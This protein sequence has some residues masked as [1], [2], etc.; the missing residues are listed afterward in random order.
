MIPI[1]T[2]MKRIVAKPLRTPVVVDDVSLLVFCQ[3][4]SDG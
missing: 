3:S 2:T 4:A 1:F